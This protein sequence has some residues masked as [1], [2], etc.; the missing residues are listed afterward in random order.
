MMMTTVINS[1]SVNPGARFTLVFCFP[2]HHLRVRHPLEGRDQ[3]VDQPASDP[4]NFD[5]S[6]NLL[7]VSRRRVAI[8]MQNPAHALSLISLILRI[9]DPRH[10]R[11]RA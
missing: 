6:P 9:L 3:G 7:N 10:E 11:R 2:N 1:I 5:K 8:P 4:V